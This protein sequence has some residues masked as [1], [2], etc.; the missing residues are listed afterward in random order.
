MSKEQ[1][2]V[3]NEEKEQCKCAICHDNINKDEKYI[4][5]ECKHEFHTNCIM[6]WFRMG[7]NRCPLCNNIGVNGNQTTNLSLQYINSELD[8]YSWVY[9]RRVLNANYKKMRRESKKKNAPKHLKAAVKKLEKQ[10]EKLKNLSDEQKI[11][12]NSTH[13]DLTAKQIIKKNLQ[14]KNKNWRIRHNINNI[15]SY[16]GLQFESCNIIIPKIQNF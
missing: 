7:H 5:P 1:N 2:I 8:T 16:I 12:L 15:K 3:L 9:K 13:T 14:L 10:E 6:T 11:F 4:L